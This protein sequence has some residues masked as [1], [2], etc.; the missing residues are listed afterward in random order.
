MGG[1]RN[2]QEDLGHRRGAGR[3][4]RAHVDDFGVERAD[5][6]RTPAVDE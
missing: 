6:V 1:W 3:V 5:D 4:S 2:G